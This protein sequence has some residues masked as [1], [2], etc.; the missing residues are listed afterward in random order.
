MKRQKNDYFNI[1]SYLPEMA[2]KRPFKK[3]VIFPEGRDHKGRISYTHY[4]FSQLEKVSN[5]YA[6]GFLNLGLKKGDRVVMLVKP[7]LDFITVTFALF[8]IGAVPVLIDPG[9]GKENLFKCIAEVKP[10]G[11]I[12]VPIAHVIRLFNKIVLNDRAFKTVKHFITVGRKWFLGGV[13]L[14]EIA[15]SSSSGEEPVLC[16]TKRSDTAAILFTTGSTGIPKGVVYEHGMFDSQVRMI[17]KTYNIT[18]DDI[19]LPAFP[20]FALFD[21]AWGI[22]S[23]VPDMN[24]AKPALVD[25][26]KIVQAVNNHGVTI[27]FG[28]PAIW[29]RVGK[30]CS[31]NE[32]KLP[33][34]KRILMAGAPVQAGIL[35]RFKDVL[36][37]DGETYTPYG[38]TES[39]PVSSISGSEILGVTKRM[40]ETGKGCCVGRPVE[41]MAVK[42]IRLT[43]D[44]IPVWDD[45]L[46]N[47]AGEIGEIAVKGGIVTKQY[48]NKRKATALSKIK[49]GEETWHRMGDVGYIDEKGRIWFCGRKAHRVAMKDKTLFSVMCEGVFNTHKD[50]FRSALVG[51]GKEN[52]KRP[53]III[54]PHEGKMPKSEK[55]KK[56]FIE[57]LLKISGKNKVTKDI[58]DVLFHPAFPV[59]IRHN[60]KIFDIRHNAKIF[61]EKLAVYAS[62]SLQST[63]AS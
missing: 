18:E 59:D 2:K 6:N 12:A 29:E 52:D 11:F 47:A 3:A 54:Q 15:D 40:T 30:F 53:V 48:F 60:A 36:P 41:G 35:Q 39:L 61:R 7:S 5:K 31:E 63:A 37:S 33:S 34:L 51:V 45:S 49:R 19:N 25:P 17:Q 58:K 14:E 9:M 46:E 32:I 20:L 28:S 21:T 1:A 26:G 24:P 50:V 55:K 22:T 43:D 8:K 56:R 13:T 4:T 16:P 57:E 62:T 23:V 42:I 44:E 27:T 10:K 38:A